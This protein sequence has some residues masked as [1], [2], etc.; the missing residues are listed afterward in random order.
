VI[1]DLLDQLHDVAGEQHRRARGGESRQQ[2]ANH[3]SGDRVD[4]LERLVQEQHGR[5]V[6]QGAAERAL[7]AHPGGVVGD[8]PLGISG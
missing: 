3:V 6:D 8:Q 4:A 5:V 7:L 2:P 1:A